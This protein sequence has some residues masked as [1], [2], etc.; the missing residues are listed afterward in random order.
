MTNDVT[1]AALSLIAE[2]ER[3]TGCRLFRVETVRIT[4]ALRAAETRGYDRAQRAS[5][6][7]P[8]PTGPWTAWRHATPAI[9]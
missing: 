6:P 4:R 3:E 7:R 2:L 8:R 5:V 1:S 9:A